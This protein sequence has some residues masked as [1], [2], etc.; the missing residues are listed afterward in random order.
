MKNS[1]K[2]QL[3]EDF[4]SCLDKL[5]EFTNVELDTGIETY[6]LVNVLNIEIDYD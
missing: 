2:F 6:E 1:D 4:L 5:V 3:V